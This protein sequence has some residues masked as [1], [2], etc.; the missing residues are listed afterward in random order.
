[1]A[2]FISYPDPFD[3]YV[4]GPPGSLSQPDPDPDP[5]GSKTYVSNGSGHRSK[6]PIM[7][8][9][10][11]IP[12]PNCLHPGSR[13]LIKEFK[14]SN[15]NKLFLSSKKYVLGCSF[16]IPDSD[17]DFLPIQDPGSRGQKDTRSRIQIRNTGFFHFFPQHCFFK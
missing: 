9:P 14:Y 10:S 8:F 6:S 15:P 16:R 11:R 3:P 5:G 2:F 12:D 17:A 7:V 13:I 1:M 4:F